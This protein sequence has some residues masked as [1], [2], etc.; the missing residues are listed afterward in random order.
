[1]KKSI[2]S[3]TAI[4]KLRSN[5]LKLSVEHARGFSFSVDSDDP[6]AAQISK[7][8]KSIA[9]ERIRKD[10][11]KRQLNSKEI[12]DLAIELSLQNEILKFDNAELTNSMNLL[13]KANKL[14]QQADQEAAKVG[15]NGK[16]QKYD[17]NKKIAHQ[18]YLRMSKAKKVSAAMLFN[19][20]TLNFTPEA[21]E[22]IQPWAL[23]TIRDWH[24]SFKK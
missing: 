5:Q 23:G 16:S 17:K 18:E 1:M 7:N 4:K 14:T 19:H 20:L 8:N 9:V 13:V 3:A 12:F 10:L 21:N 15:G 11:N 22:G 24:R 6:R 2:T